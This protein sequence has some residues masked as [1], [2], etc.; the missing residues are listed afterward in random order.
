MS[1][2]SRRQLFVRG[3]ALAVGG[4][5]LLAGCGGPSIPTPTVSPTGTI[6]AQLD[7]AFSVL[8]DAMNTNLGGRYLFGGVMNDRAPIT[9]T[10]LDDLAA[11]QLT[12]VIEQGAE[13]QTM[14]VE[15]GR[16]VEVELALHGG[17]ILLVSLSGED[18]EPLDCTVS[19]LDEAGRQVNGTL[20]LSEIMAAFSDGTL[21]SKEQRVG[22]LSPGKYR[23]TVVSDDGRKTT[24]PVTL[25][26]QAERKL[27]IRL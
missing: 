2:L 7:E 14:R 12:D 23:V 8:K 25:S 15:E 4:A 10:S 19:V 13:S 22:P 18:G 26:G 21:N 9:A 6:R 5:A 11:Q 17:T 1:A 27:N 20:A 24:K 16:T 3:S